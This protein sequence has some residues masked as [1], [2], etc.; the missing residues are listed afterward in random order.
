MNWRDEDEH[1]EN[2]KWARGG[3][4]GLIFIPPVTGPC[5]YLPREVPYLFVSRL[6]RGSGFCTKEA[7]ALSG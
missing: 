3:S 6:L 7:M 2:P 1:R 4:Q 5:I